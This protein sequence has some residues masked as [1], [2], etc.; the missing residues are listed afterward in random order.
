M[1]RM[2]DQRPSQRGIGR[3]CSLK[4]LSRPFATEWCRWQRC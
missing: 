2:G 3:E 4:G 1:K